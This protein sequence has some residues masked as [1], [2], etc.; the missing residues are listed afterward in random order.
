[1]I[2][3]IVSIMSTGIKRSD[4]FAIGSLK[5]RYESHRPFIKNKE[6]AEVIAKTLLFLDR[7]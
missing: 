2:S 5:D 3:I 7:L 6:N 1:M 4:S